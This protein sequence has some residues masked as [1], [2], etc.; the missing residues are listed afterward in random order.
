[1]TI[2]RFFRYGIAA[3]KKIFEAHPGAYDGLVIPAHLACDQR[4]LATF[5]RKLNKP[6]FVDPMTFSFAVEDNDF[7]TESGE[8]KR[9][10]RKL[11]EA[12]QWPVAIDFSTPHRLTAQAVAAVI[13]RSPERWNSFVRSIL[14]LQ[15]KLTKDPQEEAEI[16]KLLKI[17]E[18]SGQELDFDPAQMLTASS[19]EWLVPPYFFFDSYE[20]PWYNINKEAARTARVLEPDEPIYACIAASKDWLSTAD[21]TIIVSDFRHADGFVV[22]IDEFWEFGQA[23]EMLT[24]LRLLVKLLS[25]GGSK[26]VFL[27]Y[28]NMFGTFLA[29][30]G[31]TGYSSGLG[32][33]DNKARLSAT[34]GLPAPRYFVPGLYQNLVREELV[35]FLRSFGSVACDCD[36]CRERKR[37]LNLQL[38]NWPDTFVDKGLFP[39]PVRNQRSYPDGE[40][41]LALKTH[42]L[43]TSRHEAERYAGLSGS[44]IAAALRE[45]LSRINVADPV[46]AR[47]KAAHLRR[48]ALALD[49]EIIVPDRVEA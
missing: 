5:V 43:L 16:K 25:Q 28:S 7:T 21:F 20:D 49:A 8:L 19:P 30:D 29:E 39:R 22:W 13:A 31:L 45:T 47:S 32:Y 35:P 17:M 9:S 41:Q 12:I 2:R 48:W 27:L 26:G 23:P 18:E 37:D 14:D 4:S 36:V 34:G 15:D 44:E 33:G 6:Y 24:R 46:F 10:Y 3:E 42:F 11:T 1:M 40:N 38:V